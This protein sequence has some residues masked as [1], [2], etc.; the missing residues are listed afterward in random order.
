M[1]CTGYASDFGKPYISRFASCTYMFPEA[2]VTMCSWYVV[3]LYIA[4]SEAHI[5]FDSQDCQLRNGGHMQV[6]CTL[7]HHIRINIQAAGVQRNVEL[8]DSTTFMLTRIFVNRRQILDVIFKGAGKQHNGFR[9]SSR[10]SRFEPSMIRLFQKGGILSAC[11]QLV[12]SNADD[13]L[14]NGRPCV[15]MSV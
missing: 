11:Y 7:H 15:I 3:K 4:C 12:P 10:L 6:K 13:W 14:K 9:L 8:C 2:N 1:Q 5:S